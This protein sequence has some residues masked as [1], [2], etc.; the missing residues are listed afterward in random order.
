M[1]CDRVL[2]NLRDGKDDG[3][4]R[5]IAL[6][7][8]WR[9]CRTRAVRKELPDGTPVRILLSPGHTLTHGDV[10]YE[11]A[12]RL[13]YI[14]MLPVPLLGATSNDPALLAK[15]AY[16]LGNLHLPVEVIGSRIATLADGP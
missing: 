7:L 11:D 13:I 2:R 14:D 6:P 1:L 9:E 16:G 5:Q 15:V 8:T 10:I 3:A 4:R 12:E